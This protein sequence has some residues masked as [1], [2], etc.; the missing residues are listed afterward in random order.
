MYKVKVYFQ[1]DLNVSDC[2]YAYSRN[3]MKDTK[4]LC[5]FYWF[6]FVFLNLTHTIVEIKKVRIREMTIDVPKLKKK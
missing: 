2:T 1:V 5:L 3:K 4:K 6:V